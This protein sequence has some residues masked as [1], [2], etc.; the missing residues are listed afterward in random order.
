L[1]TSI[2][3]VE[4]PRPEDCGLGRARDFKIGGDDGG[5]TPRPLGLAARGLGGQNYSFEWGEST[6]RR[7]WIAAQ[8]ALRLDGGQARMATPSG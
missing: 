2:K 4:Q 8:V 7:R 5:R 6:L 3:G 1:D